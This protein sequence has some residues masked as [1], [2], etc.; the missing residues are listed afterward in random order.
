MNEQIRPLQQSLMQNESSANANCCYLHRLHL[1]KAGIFV[2]ISTGKETE[3]GISN[4]ELLARRDTG[5]PAQVYISPVVDSGSWSQ[6]AKYHSL[7]VPPPTCVTL[8]VAPVCASG[9]SSVKGGDNI[10]THLIGLLGRLNEVICVNC[11]DS[12]QHICPWHMLIALVLVMVVSIT[13]LTAFPVKGKGK[14]FLVDAV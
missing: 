7:A 1:N 14:C 13:Y 5:T 6:T 8:G 11:S 2:P 12:I 10:S 4:L 3:A 9:S